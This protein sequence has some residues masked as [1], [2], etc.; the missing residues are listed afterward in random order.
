MF[1]NKGQTQAIVSITDKCPLVQCACY[2]TF[3]GEFLWHHLF[4]VW[5][6]PF[7]NESKMSDKQILLQ[8]NDFPH[9]PCSL[10]IYD[11]AHK[12]IFNSNHYFRC[13]TCRWTLSHL[14]TLF[15]TQRCL[16]QQDLFLHQFLEMIVAPARM[17]K[18]NIKLKV[19][20]QKI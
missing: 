5:E 7:L 15:Y 20:M 2:R 18:C 13:S 11:L 3:G 9:P 17:T 16:W 10:S 6:F 19:N 1:P 14:Y 8:H 12:I 4:K